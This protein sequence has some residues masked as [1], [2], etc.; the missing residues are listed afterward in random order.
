MGAPIAQYPKWPKPEPKPL[1]LTLLFNS[2]IALFLYLLGVDKDFI[3]LLVISHAIGFSIHLYSYLFGCTLTRLSPSQVLILS[4][5]SGVLQGALIAWAYNGF[6]SESWG[7]MQQ[8]LLFGLLFG[9]VISYFFYSREQTSQMQDALVAAQMEQLENQR[10][11]AEMRLS[12]LQAQ[13][14]P[15]FLFNTLSNIRSLIDVDAIKA[16]QMVDYLSEFLRVSLDQTRNTHTT[17]AQEIATVESYLGIQK[18]RMGERLHTRINIDAAA[19]PCELPALTL[20]PL[21]EN[22]L[23]HG[24]APKVEGGT[25][26]I[27]AFINEQQLICEVEDNGLG[28]SDTP[29]ASGI[30]LDNVKQRLRLL[31][32]DAA[33]LTISST[34]SDGVMVRLEIPACRP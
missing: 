18:I 1:L 20:Q 31:H 9:V 15:H 28:L 10:H 23:K 8:L 3:E 14:E 34:S 33:S 17:L 30:G 22:A 11:L 32:G 13:M 7:H 4:I 21:V 19:L 12:V 2:L 27:R 24:L 6:S 25:V 26:S 5:S 29:S 16:G